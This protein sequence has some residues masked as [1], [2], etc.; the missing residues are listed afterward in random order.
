MMALLRSILFALVFWPGSV[1]FVL[2]AMPL[3]GSPRAVA[4]VAD[5]WARFHG[6]CVRRLLGIR[7]VI[8]GRVP[9]EP[10]LIAA[11][12]QS[13]FE[14][15]ALLDLVDRPIIVL[16]A[17]L[18]RIP[19]WGWLARRYGMIPVERTGSTRAMREMLRAAQAARASGRPVVI[20][21]EGTRVRP[22]EAPELRPGFAGL[23]KA[24]GL[25][26]VPLAVDSGK[27]LPKHRFVRRAGVVNFRF[28]EPIPPG[29]P[30]KEIE[31]LVH[32]AINRDPAAG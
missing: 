23:Y 25:P 2:A 20:F 22:G 24:L 10:V 3:G 32:A 14:T 15:I 21:P 9:G 19:M 8:H 31:A 1:L 26:A 28:G 11:K 4:V 27:L 12:H 13:M 7:L 18:A 29:L 5:A 16:K 30:R 17:E 6:W